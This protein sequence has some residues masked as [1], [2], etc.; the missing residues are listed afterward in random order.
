M[1]ATEKYSCLPAYSQRIRYNPAHMTSSIELCNMD[2]ESCESW[3]LNITNFYLKVTFSRVQQF[4]KFHRNVP[5]D[6]GLVQKHHQVCACLNKNRR[7]DERL[8][9]QAY[10]SGC[11][12]NTQ[13]YISLCRFFESIFCD[14]N[15]CFRLKLTLVCI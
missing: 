1:T 13:L 14:T 15:T 11:L 5:V 3:D 2:T 10:L 6:D 8:P 4:M 9:A 12:L 7:F